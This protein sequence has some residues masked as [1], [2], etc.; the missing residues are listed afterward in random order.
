MICTSAVNAGVSSKSCRKCYRF[1]CLPNWHDLVQEMGRVNRLL[2]ATRGADGYYLFLNVPTFIFM[3]ART[4]SQSVDAVR[5]RHE[6]VLFEILTFLVLSDKCLHETIEE[7]IENP[8]TYTSR[9]PCSDMC[10]FCT[11]G[12][13]QYS[14]KISK[15]HLVA[16]LTANIFDSGAVKAEK[17]V[18]LLTDKSNK[19]AIKEKVWGKNHAKDDAGKI[20]GLV[21]MLIASKLVSLRLTSKALVGNEKIGTKFVEVHLMKCL[22][23]DDDGAHDDLAIHDSTKWKGFHFIE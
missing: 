13:I 9:G 7:H 12:N 4:Q 22:V 5:A 19:H 18:T 20:H 23:K 16:A 2:M 11:E 15:E 3:W 6:S 10:S 14:G 17:L 21:L 8:A 1:G